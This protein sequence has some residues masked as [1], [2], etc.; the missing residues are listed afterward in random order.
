MDYGALSLDELERL[1]AEG[2]KGAQKALEAYSEQQAQR[3]RSVVAQ[4]FD[5]AHLVDGRPRAEF[6]RSRLAPAVEEAQQERDELRG[7]SE[8]GIAESSGNGGPCSLWGSPGLVLP[9]VLR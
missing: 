5:P 6:V 7:P 4:R 9:I 8:H 1:A 2:D 3:V